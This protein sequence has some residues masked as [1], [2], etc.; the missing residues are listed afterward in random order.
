MTGK[1]FNNNEPEL[2]SIFTSLFIEKKQAYPVHILQKS[3]LL[4][5]YFFLDKL[6]INFISE[7]IYT[8]GIL[9]INSL[10]FFNKN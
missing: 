10:M 9:I 6:M 7:Y 3:S 4:S 8:A 2:L 5:L 1:N